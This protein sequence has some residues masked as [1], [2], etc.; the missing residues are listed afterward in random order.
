MF[1]RGIR[2]IRELAGSWASV[3]ALLASLLFLLP[4]F[5][6]AAV[7]ADLGRCSSADGA[8]ETTE[9]N[10]VIIGTTGGCDENSLQGAAARSQVLLGLT[11]NGEVRPGFGHGG[12]TLNTLVKGEFVEKLVAAT[13]R[14]LLVLTNRR[15]RSYDSSGGQRSDFGGQGQV[16][17]ISLS[18]MNVNP[19]DLVAAP[20]G[21]FLVSGY[22][23]TGGAIALYDSA[24]HLNPS[25][26]E[27]GI[28]QT[29]FRSPTA[30]GR[31]TQGRVLVATNTRLE[32]YLQD[33]E[34]DESFGGGAGFADLSAWPIIGVSVDSTGQITVVSGG[35]D[36]LYGHPA[37]ARIFDADGLPKPIPP[38]SRY[39]FNAS[40]GVPYPGGVAFAILPTR[41]GDSRFSVASS[42]WAAPRDYFPTPGAALARGI[43]P[44]ADGSI[45]AVGYSWDSDCGSYC[46]DP[47][48]MAVLKLDPASG[49]PVQGF[50]RGG[51]RLIPSNSCPFGKGGAIGD[52]NLCRVMPPSVQANANVF[53]RLSANPEMS[54]TVSLGEPP[55]R[56]WGT[57][58]RFAVKLPRGLRLKV[59]AQDLVTVE[60]DPWQP[61]R[62][63]V[64]SRKIVVF[65]EPVY[66]Y[67]DGQ[68]YGEV[69]DDLAIT[70]RLRLQKGALAPITPP[71]AKKPGP[72]HIRGSFFP[73]AGGMEGVNH[74]IWFAPNSEDVWLPVKVGSRRR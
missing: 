15:I 64:S 16:V 62:I 26:G 69:G 55:G 49:D 6:E 59:G 32:R 20:D 38:G 1:Y 18:E 24:G 54:M 43:T 27:G 44:L 14:N 2:E 46:G 7:P 39:S 22:K 13:D 28:V 11:G 12:A 50:A 30:L 73:A 9:R 21:G 61:F 42:G 68:Y 25:F 40:F 48:R 17:P 19:T 63:K 70:L 45:L 65:V 29:S 10:L 66:P 35:F 57:R 72:L 67:W 8:V 60:P 33:G 71:V 23:S 36:G 53:G 34:K 5:A 3:A 74:L 31:D 41:G 58:Q 37:N 51:S 52:W 4:T 56:L 47:R